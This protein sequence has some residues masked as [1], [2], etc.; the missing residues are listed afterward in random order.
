VRRRGA[1]LNRNDDLLGGFVQGVG[2]ED[3]EM[4]D[5]PKEARQRDMHYNK[6]RALQ[7]G[8]EGGAIL[9]Q[10]DLKKRGSPSR[11]RPAK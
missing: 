2:G 7:E 8:K 3:K 9:S 1:K 6:C 5:E 10:R 11:G 4:H